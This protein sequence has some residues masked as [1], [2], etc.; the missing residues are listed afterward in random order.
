MLTALLLFA[1][2]TVPQVVM[3]RNEATSLSASQLEERLL[4]GRT[5]GKIARVEI[6]EDVAGLPARPLSYVIFH[7][8]GRP[9]GGRFCSARRFVASF[10]TLDGKL[11]RTIEPNAHA[12]Q[13]RLLNITE[14]PLVAIVDGEANAQACA[15]AT[16]FAQ[17]PPLAPDGGRRI[18]ADVLK[19]AEQARRTGKASVPVTCTDVRAPTSACDGHRVLAALD[20]K[21]LGFVEAPNRGQGATTRITFDAP[22]FWAVEVTGSGGVE[23]IALTRT[24]AATS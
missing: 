15:S 22:D 9:G 20:W 7:E 14:Y 16:K 17:L 10:S 5:H 4:A 11:P 24:Y 3:T 19:V 6:S 23:K 8:E 21:T 2:Q 13:R 18:V 1:A 12:L